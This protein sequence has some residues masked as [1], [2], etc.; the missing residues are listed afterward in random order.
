MKVIINNLA[1]EY[2]D[3][4]NGPV[5][6][7]LHG[8]MTS[9]HTFD[10]LVVLLSGS[11]RMIRLDLPGFGGSE[12]P[13]EAWGV[14]EYVEFVKAFNEKLGITPEVLV[15][16]SFGGRILLKGVSQGIF[17]AKKLIFV[18]SAGIKTHQTRAILF[19]V[20]AK[21][22]KIALG[23]LPSG[24]RERFR[25][26]LYRMAG[27]TDYLDVSSPMMKETFL[28]STRED[29][30]DFARNIRVPSLL[31]WGQNDLV[32]PLSDGKRLQSLILG[33]KLEVIRDARHFVHEEKPEIVASL[34]R[35]FLL[36]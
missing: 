20:A 10:A 21:I 34:I 15:G 24:I 1:I 31:I 17:S 29:L 36:F 3:E 33:S 23:F 27:S 18:A 7:L 22:G 32:T 16:H 35:E 19:L 26:K 8:W 6:I 12:A 11:F 28:R 14:G 13:K 30:T 5:M 4:G 2:S 25:R 9:L